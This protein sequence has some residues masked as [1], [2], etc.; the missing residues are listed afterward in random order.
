MG[1]SSWMI[2]S[3]HDETQ[4]IVGANFVPGRA[5]AQSSYRSEVAGMFSIIMFISLV[6]EFYE[7]DQGSAVVQVVL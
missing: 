7:L 5:Q 2:L 1:T 3:K 6:V 4:I